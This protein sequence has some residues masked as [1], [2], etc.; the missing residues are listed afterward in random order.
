MSTPVSSSAAARRKLP[1]RYTPL[2]FSFYMA[3]IMGALMCSAIVA[4][5]TGVGDGYGLRVLRAYAVGM[6][7][8]F[9]CVL[10]VRPLVMKLVAWTVEAPPAA[11]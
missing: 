10:L 3:A 4:L 8:A 2:V 9:V 11:H 7:V 5:T 1:R 6:P